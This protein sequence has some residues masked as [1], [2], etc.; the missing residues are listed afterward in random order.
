[1]NRVDAHA[2]VFHRDLPMAPGRRYTPRHDA[3]ADA[4]LAVLDA[5]DIARALLVQPSFL[6][7]DNSYVLDAVSAHPDR[8]RAV[9]VIDTGEPSTAVAQVPSWHRAGA[10]GIRL[11]LV[12][13]G[14]P[15][16]HA[17]EWRALGEQ[18]AEYDWHLEVQAREAQW[19][20]LAPALATWP[21]SVVLDHVG[22]PASTL[23][24]DRAAI[25][26]LAALS[27]VWTK[28]SG[29]YRSADGAAQATA[30]AIRERAGTGRLLWGSDWPW[31]QHETGRAYGKLLATLHD[32]LPDPKDVERV[33]SAN[34]ARLLD[35]N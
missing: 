4:Y 27:H 14:V 5:H 7:T 9:L 19:T 10:R 25:L 16:L 12:G 11:N 2:H 3:T 30:V 22:L 34:P 28:L 20:Q 32:L 13:T 18:M 8:F 24:D 1:M 26:H 15:P 29:F 21:S 33:L 31:T 23:E 35:W 17:A 6:G